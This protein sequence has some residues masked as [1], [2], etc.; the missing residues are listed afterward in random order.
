MINI[1]IYNI[2]K[3]YIQPFKIIYGHYALFNY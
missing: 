1:A 3:G 2:R